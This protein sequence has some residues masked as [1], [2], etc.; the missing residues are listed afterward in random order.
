M[1]STWL[2]LLTTIASCSC[3]LV[4]TASRRPAAK[5]A[6]AIVAQTMNGRI[7]DLSVYFCGLGAATARR[8]TGRGALVGG[9]TVYMYTDERPV[10]M[11]HGDGAGLSVVGRWSMVDSQTTVD[12]Q[13]TNDDR[14]NDDRPN[15]SRPN[16]GASGA[17][18]AAPLTRAR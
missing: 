4:V 2:D 8:G 5:V 18:A 7:R 16:D 9:G 11:A 13:S 17:A 12:R 14:P 3:D 1:S 15:D 10:R 6:C